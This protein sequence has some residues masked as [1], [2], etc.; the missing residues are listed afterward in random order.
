MIIIIFNILRTSNSL[1]NIFVNDLVL[2]ILIYN[3]DK[4]E[5]L[6]EVIRSDS[7]VGLV[8]ALLKMLICNIYE[9]YQL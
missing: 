7:N 8:M 4:F 6:F 1:L 9:Y 3:I 2:G 5:K